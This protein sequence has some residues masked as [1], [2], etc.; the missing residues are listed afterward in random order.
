MIYKI[1][2]NLDLG[3]ANSD[4]EIS[5]FR[6]LKN[7]SAGNLT[8]MCFNYA[9]K[10]KNLEGIEDSADYLYEYYDMIKFRNVKREDI[11]EFYQDKEILHYAIVIKKGKTIADTIVRGKFGSC[12]IYEHKLKDTPTLYGNKIS[13]WHNRGE[14]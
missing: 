12:G 7:I 4:K 14:L 3:F 13:F 6:Q 1:K 2:N 11:V 9:L 10:N 5:N 8:D